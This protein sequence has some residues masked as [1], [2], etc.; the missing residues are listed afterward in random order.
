MQ[1]RRRAREVALQTLFQDEFKQSKGPFD[2]SREKDQ[3]VLA[4]AQLLVDGVLT[5]LESIDKL[6]Q[7]HSPNWKVQRMALVDKNILRIAIFE[8]LHSIEP[9]PFKAAI[10]E[11]IELAKKFGSNDSGS[12]VNGILDQVA[13]NRTEAAPNK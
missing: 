10:N 7:D 11:A 6:I 8:L 1:N 12:F 4:Y 3:A 9:I 5:N 13:K 2:P